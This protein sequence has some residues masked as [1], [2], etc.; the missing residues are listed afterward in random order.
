[1]LS[2]DLFDSKFEKKLH[3][4]A[5]DNLEARRIDDLNM[6]ML[7]L[8]DRAKEPA[9]KKNPAA[10]A[11][12]KKQFQK[13]K[14]E[15]DSYFKINPATGMDP[16]GSLG[17][18]KGKLDEV[19]PPQRPPAKGLLK[20]KDLVTPQQRVVGA[21]PP[22]TS[23]MGKARDT[24]SS[25]ANWL[26]GKDDTGPTYESELKENDP[27]SAI[28]AAKFAYEQIRKAHDTNV[29]TA[30]I[31]WM[32]V[33]EPVTMSRNQIYHTVNKL[34]A[35]SRQN[36]NAF[37]LQTLANRNNFNLWLGSQKKIT[38]RP[39]LKQPTD[40]FQPELPLGKPKIGPVQERIQKK[41][42]DDIQAG[43]VK[44]ARELQK[45]RAQY[46][47]ARS[48]VEAVARAE[49]DSSERSGQ[50]IAAIR[51]ANEKQDALLKQLVALDREQGKEIDSLDQENNGLEKQLARIQATNARLQQTIGQMTGTKKSSRDKTQITQPVATSM[52]EPDPTTAKKVQDLEAQINQ[53]QA[54]PSTPDIEKKIDALQSRINALPAQAVQ[55]LNIDQDKKPTSKSPRPQVPAG[56]LDIEPPKK[57][58]ATA[59][60]S[61]SKPK[62]SRSKVATPASQ[63]PDNDL[64]IINI[65]EPDM[66]AVQEHGGGI[67]PK[68][69]WQSMMPE[70]QPQELINRYLAIDAETDVEAVRAAIQAISR[71]PGLGANSKSRLLGQIGMIIR[72]HRLP[73]GRSYYT[74]MQQYMEEQDIAETVADV[75]SLWAQ[76]YHKLAPKI[77][78]HRDSFLAGQLY[79]ELE[80][81]AELHGAEGE[82]KRMM[83][84]AR[85]R[86]HMEYDTNPGG[87]QN[88]FWFL[89]FEDNMEE[90]IKSQLAGAALAGALALGAGSASAR[91][92]GDEDPGVNRLTGK[93]NVTQAVQGDQVKPLAPT[94]FSKEYLQSVV[95]GTHPRPMITKEKAQALLNQLKEQGVAEGTD[96]IKKRMSK[97]E[98][99]A[100]AANRAGDDAKCK[101]YQQ[102][103]QSLKQKLSQSIAEGW[104]DAIVARRTGQP[105]TPYSVYIDGREWKAFANDDHARAVAEKVQANLKRQ[106]RDQTVTIA[107][108]K[109]KKVQ[110]SDEQLLE[111]VKDVASATA[112]IACLLTGGSLSGCATAPQ[113]TSAQQVLKT[114]QD[115]G[116]TVQT[117]KKITRAGVEAEVNQEIRN[118]LRGGVGAPQELNNS[119]ILRVW[120]RLQGQPPVAPEP[121]APEYGPA[122]PV[123]RPA[124]F[125]A[126]EIV[127]KEDFFRER[128]RLLRMI[129]Q[130]TNPANKQILKSAIRQLEN[131]AE[132]EGWITM[133]QRLVRE[134]SDSGEAVEMAIMRRMLVAHTDL[135]VEF[136][137]DKVV[138]AI[139]E[140][141]YDVGDVD[142]IGSSDVSGWVRQVKQILGADA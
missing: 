57:R 66:F 118:L 96:D 120:R 40:P 60:T 15:R 8:L 39:Q 87:F 139:E 46:P 71:D 84:T 137:L 111:G 12:L 63:I 67:G 73:I 45:L 106:G 131:R 74:Y 20:G 105:R 132:N 108:S 91:V 94:G 83:A 140:V 103:I 59:K 129:D 115:I 24:L 16:T 54:R 51:G 136:G 109:T 41:K 76:A 102:K 79:D 128:D 50:Q 53:L 7:E 72:R 107:P 95:D 25:F 114:G 35:M 17:T 10:L 117:A 61:K 88:W 89:P 62:T 28:N 42:S 33:G 13:I 49:I 4:G 126:R 30:T 80:N 138:Q 90:G 38:P 113:Q 47:A 56:D 9:Y 55:A 22:Q 58:I 48:D 29:D 14:A 64:N 133:Q 81:I 92:T 11:G 18:T 121:Q 112:V 77:E 68:Q 70:G 122:D 3:E 5:V 135:I 100:L 43:D 104:S 75:K 37:A 116:R 82:F 127:S 130:D 85:G 125:E 141:A 119:G 34:K 69:H 134:D 65:D 44:V 142:E 99:L 6:R 31:R 124:Q 101:M 93:P 36:R 52:S 27:N 110:E 1:M 2:L 78:R 123:K 26:A 21:T 23:M 32:N 97:L 98:A 19:D 86:A